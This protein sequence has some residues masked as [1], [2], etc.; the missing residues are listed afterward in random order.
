MVEAEA[1]RYRRRIEGIDGRTYEF[2]ALGIDLNK[3]TRDQLFDFVQDY[4]GTRKLTVEL[5]R[6]DGT[7]WAYRSSDFLK[8]ELFQKHIGFERVEMPA[9]SI[10][11]ARPRR[12]AEERQEAALLTFWLGSDKYSVRFRGETLPGT[13][14]EFVANRDKIAGVWEADGTRISTT[15]FLRRVRETT[16]G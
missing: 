6:E 7:R 1:M 2:T 4:A 15:E 14:E 12:V 16:Q 8:N 10:L 11:A 13:Y 9:E 5:V 3:M